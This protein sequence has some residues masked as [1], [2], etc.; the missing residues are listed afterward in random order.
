MCVV[1]RFSV[2]FVLKTSVSIWLSLTIFFVLIIAVIVVVV[3]DDDFVL[4]S[5]YPMSNLPNPISIFL[6][7][8]ANI[9]PIK[10]AQRNYSIKQCGLFV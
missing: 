5:A 10:C 6:F 1:P 9:P 7:L 4:I 2:H 8:H 3:G